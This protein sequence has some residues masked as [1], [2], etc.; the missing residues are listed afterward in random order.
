MKFLNVFFIR[1]LS[2]GSNAIAESVD[3]CPCKYLDFCL[4]EETSESLRNRLMAE[5]SW[6]QVQ[7]NENASDYDW[8]STE[9]RSAEKLLLESKFVFN[10]VRTGAP[11]RYIPESMKLLKEFDFSGQLFPV[12][13][14]YPRYNFYFDASVPRILGTYGRPNE[15]MRE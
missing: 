7:P 6:V 13:S 9:K 10:A 3:R 1:I 2:L 12:F 14:F 15:P 4:A 8:Q 5:G 11:K